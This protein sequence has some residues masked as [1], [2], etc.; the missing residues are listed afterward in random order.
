MERIF[1]L[2][3]CRFRIFNHIEVEFKMKQIILGFLV[4]GIFGGVAFTAELKDRMVLPAENGNVVF[5]HNNH[6][7]EVQGDCK[8]CHEG[9][10]GKI[11]GFGKKYAHKNCIPC[12]RTP[13]MPEGPT[14][15]DGCHKK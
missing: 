14:D 2:N 7:G 11:A 6:V 5:Y 9:K 4:L 15:C 3:C 8:R 1:D 13:G 10:P 12:H